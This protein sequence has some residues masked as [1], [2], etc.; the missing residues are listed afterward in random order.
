MSMYALLPK[1]ETNFISGDIPD[2]DYGSIVHIDLETSGLDPHKSELWVVNVGYSPIGDGT[3]QKAEICRVPEIKECPPNIKKLLENPS[4]T[5]I[6]HNAPFDAV[7]LFVKWGIKTQTVR[8]TRI[9]AKYTRRRGNSYAALA[10]IVTGY[11]LPKGNIT[12]SKWDLPFDRWSS[13]MKQYCAYDVAF[14]LK[15]YRYLEMHT[16]P[17]LLNRYLVLSSQW[18]LLV[19]LLPK[20]VKHEDLRLIPY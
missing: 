19:E 8:C 16:P 11:E 18:D 7:W 17:D 3:F 14:G 5:K 2:I 20:L 4:I 15:I 10:K 6:M 12:V 9:L 1:V 13:E